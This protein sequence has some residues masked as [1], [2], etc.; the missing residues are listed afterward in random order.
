MNPIQFR[1]PYRCQNGHFR[2]A[3]TIVLGDGDTRMTWGDKHPDCK[4]PTGD[5]GE[6][7]AV[8][9]PHQ[10]FTGNQDSKENDIFDGD[11]V[12]GFGLVQWYIADLEGYCGWTFVDDYDHRHEFFYLTSPMKV[13][14]NI[15]ETPNR[16]AGT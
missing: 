3:Y 1:T 7:F 4:C 13:V 5:I 11:L 9:G 14:G 2:W 8:I 6:G 10:M 15:Y 16:K 12:E